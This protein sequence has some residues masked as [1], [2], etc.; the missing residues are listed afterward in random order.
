MKP[1]PPSRPERE[2]EVAVRE[3]AA[4]RGPDQERALSARED[5]LS[6]REEAL[7]AR[8]DAARSSADVERL[9]GQLRDANE[10]LIVT[11]V[12]AQTM[13]ED[14]RAEAARAEAEIARLVGRVRG[15]NERLVAATAH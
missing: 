7:R 1:E 2:R 14:T 8:E 9:M 4:N 11:A 5:A 12:Q 13:S 15:A 3:D 6:V 10:R